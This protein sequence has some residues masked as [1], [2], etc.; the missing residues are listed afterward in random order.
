MPHKSV[1]ISQSE[2]VLYRLQTQAIIIKFNKS[3][4]VHKKIEI[5][6]QYKGK[7]MGASLFSVDFLYP[8]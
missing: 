2:F 4:Y 7:K 3:S 6:P 8:V 5:F 1:T